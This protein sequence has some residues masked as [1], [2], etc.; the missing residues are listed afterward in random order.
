M[1]SSQLDFQITANVTTT[2]GQTDSTTQ[3]LLLSPST[4][5]GLSTAKAVYAQLLGDLASYQSMPSFE[6]SYLMIPQFSGTSAPGPSP[7]LMHTQVS[8]V[9]C[10]VPANCCPCHF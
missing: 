10:H 4:P 6:Y 2:E 8:C 5:S 9:V 1:G 7:L 3:T